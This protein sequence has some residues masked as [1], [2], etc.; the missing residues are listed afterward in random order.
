[1]IGNIEQATFTGY[2][3]TCHIVASTREDLLHAEIDLLMRSRIDDA[4]RCEWT[5]RGKVWR[6][7]I[8]TTMSSNR[9]RVGQRRAWVVSLGQ[10][11]PGE[12][13]W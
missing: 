5:S 8:I 12:L 6:S 7:S 13:Y 4:I 10:D 11:V 1:M 3:G 9:G 2:V